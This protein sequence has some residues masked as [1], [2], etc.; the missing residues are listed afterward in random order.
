M[1]FK[2]ESEN[3]KMKVVDELCER[4]VG[5]KPEFN[6]NTCHEDCTLQ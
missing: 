4:N 2:H 3:D 1:C 6:Y 5:P